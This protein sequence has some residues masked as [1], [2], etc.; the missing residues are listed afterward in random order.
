M[1]PFDQPVACFMSRDLEGA[2]PDT[3]LERLVRS[4]HG[5]GISGIPISDSNGGL[6]GVVS[7]TD[8]I[9][10]GVIQSG[11]RSSSPVMP[12]PR[13]CAKDVMSH[14]PRTTSSGAPLHHA[15]RLMSEHAI[16]RLFVLDDE[17]LVGVITTVDLATAV[18]DARVEL[19]LSEVMTGQVISIDARAPISAAVDLLAR[20]G[21]TGLIVTEEERPIGMFTQENAL[22]SR[23]LP[24]GTPVDE[25]YDA[26]VICLPIETKLHRAAA[27]AAELA[28]RRIV[29]CRAREAVGVVSGLDFARI[30]AGSR[31]R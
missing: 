13:N 29:V 21:V 3:P 25:T 6:V 31:G 10:L 4:M 5:R 18:R 7:R 24:R 20:I 16:H 2:A 8:L 15:A 28:V 23:D 27:M 11:R 19:P 1:H 9:A 22:A 12:L 30:V 17:Q 26:G 14:P